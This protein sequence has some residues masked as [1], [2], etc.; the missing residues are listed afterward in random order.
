M[1]KLTPTQKDVVTALQAGAATITELGERTGRSP[2]ALSK[3]VA[4]L[5]SAGHL[6]ERGPDGGGDETDGDG[7]H[8]PRWALVDPTD[9]AEDAAEATAPHADDDDGGGHA[10]TDAQA[11]L[12]DQ[13]EQ[14]GQG[15]VKV[16]RGCQ[17]QLPQVCPTC[18]RA[19]LSY[20]PACRM[21]REQ[22]RRNGEPE[23]LLSGLP[24]LRPGELRKLVLD[25]MTTHALPD[26]HGVVGWTS[27]RIGVY[28][29]GR[30]QHAIALALDRLVELGSAEQIGESPRRYK[31][32]TDATPDGSD[33]APQ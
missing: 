16:C 14:T 20:C 13:P 30:N 8:E 17:A 1:D 2:R 5:A 3:A 21:S 18:E 7:E 9:V 28:L 15:E 32:V 4:D 6:A 26:H 22:R 12:T 24:K 11:D 31:P 10:A 23:V 19:T 25:V 33:P 27:G 29:P